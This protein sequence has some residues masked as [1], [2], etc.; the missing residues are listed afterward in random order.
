LDKKPKPGQLEPKSAFFFQNLN[1]KPDPDQLEPKN[2]F[3]LLKFE[4][5]TWTWSAGTQKCIF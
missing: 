4:Q 1:K 3:F 2:A 5:G